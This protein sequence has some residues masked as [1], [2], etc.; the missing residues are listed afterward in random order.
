MPTSEPSSYVASV[1]RAGALVR[2]A[3]R[4]STSA[5]AIRPSL[6]GGWA[7]PRETWREATL[8]LHRLDRS[9]TIKA[10][11][12]LLFAIRVCAMKLG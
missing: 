2:R 10:T 12:W 1:R 8:R 9:W 11:A 3:R 4:F 7:N 6:K 5:P